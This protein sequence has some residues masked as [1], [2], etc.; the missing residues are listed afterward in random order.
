MKAHPVRCGIASMEA[1]VEGIPDAQLRAL[2]GPGSPFELVTGSHGLPIFRHAPSTLTSVYRQARNRAAA[3]DSEILIVGSQRITLR[4]LFSMVDV[5]QNALG[6]ERSG[7]DARRVAIL[8][9]DPVDWIS[10]FIAITEMGDVAVLIPTRASADRLSAYLEISSPECLIT[11]SGRD[12]PD[13]CDGNATVTMRW[14]RSASSRFVSNLELAASLPGFTRNIDVGDEAII[15]FTSGSSGPPKGVR[16]SHEGVISGLWNMML[17][18]AWVSRLNAQHEGSSILA[19]RPK[20]PGATLV[21]GSMMHISGYTQ[22]LLRLVSSG[23]MI[24]VE[25]WDPAE[26]RRVVIEENATTISGA[27]HAMIMELSSAASS[28]EAL[29]IEAFNLFGRS[30]DACALDSIRNAFPC[31]RTGI[32]YGM[33]ETNGAIAT[34]HGE[35]L[36][37]FPGSVGRVVPSVQLR[38]TDRHGAELPPGTVGRIHVRGSMLMLGYCHEVSINDVPSDRWHFTGDLGYLTE[39]GHLTIVDRDSNSGEICGTFV[40][41]AAIESQIRVCGAAEE[42]AAVVLADSAT[43]LVWIVE[44]PAPRTSPKN[45]AI[46]L[47]VHLGVPLSCLHIIPVQ[48]IPRTSSGKPDR[49]SLRAAWNPI[50][51]TNGV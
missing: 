24:L 21:V 41:A 14:S 36:F 42:C 9:S 13:Y 3:R 26:V 16:L 19:R 45:L 15:A 27:T 17:S 48:K 47:A 50:P 29:P 10:A 44:L 34:S 31:S 33:T 28:G 30:L 51:D 49:Q 4:R 22:V 8:L 37:A 46:R 35:E 11:D 6:A 23:R 40:Y 38:V 25:S 18:G 20:V 2:V 5:M 12:L 39:T 43:I 1:G 32:G 7:G